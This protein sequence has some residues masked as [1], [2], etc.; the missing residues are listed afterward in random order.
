GH[1]T[2]IPFQVPS[3]LLFKTND[4]MQFAFEHVVNQR[5]VIQVN[6]LNHPAGAAADWARQNLSGAERIE[7][8][9]QVA[10][11]RAHKNPQAALQVLAEM[12]GTDVYASSFGVMM[13]GL[14]QISGLGQQA[15]DLI[16]N[17]DLNARE[18]ARTI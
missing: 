7:F 3:F 15:A 2:R 4:A 12:K 10:Y 13:R 9:Q 8:Y 11:E 16:A 14:V 5:A 6:A 18:P 17:A 1:A